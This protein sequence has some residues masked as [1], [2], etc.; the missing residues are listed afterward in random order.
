MKKY[1]SLISLMSL[2][3]LAVAT[4]APATAQAVESNATITAIA[5]SDP[6]KPV[7]P[8][9]PTNP[10]DPTDPGNGGETPEQPG[11]LQINVVPNL[12]FGDKVEI[13]PKTV[14][15]S[16]KNET[17]PFA[18]VSDLRGTGAGW[19]LNVSLGNFLSTDNKAIVGAT[20]SFSG[21]EAVTSNQLTENAAV[22][23]NIKLTA[24]S[25]GAQSLMK[26]TAGNG[27]GTWLARFVNTGTA[28][29]GNTKIMFEAPTDQVMANTAYKAIMTW[30]LADTPTI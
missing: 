30:Q 11:D 20:I 21:G 14:S 28:A 27:K 19:S 7:D 1:I 29:T 15:T 22:T 13:T 6:V 2:S 9:D 5:G 17:T 23:N 4:L 18:Q 26:A 8:T 25:T 10:T 16:L 24:G 3:A 12:N